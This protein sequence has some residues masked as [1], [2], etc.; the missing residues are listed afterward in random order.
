MTTRI[1]LELSIDDSGY[2]PRT[3]IKADHQLYE[4]WDDEQPTEDD[5]KYSASSLTSM[6]TKLY[7]ITQSND[8]PGDAEYYIEDKLFA[9]MVDGCHLEL[10]E[11]ILDDP[12]LDK[13]RQTEEIEM[14]FTNE[15]EIVYGDNQQLE[16]GQIA[17]YRN[18][19]IRA[20]DG[21]DSRSNNIVNKEGKNV[22]NSKEEA[23]AAIKDYYADSDANVS[24][25]DK[26]IFKINDNENRYDLVMSNGKEIK[27]EEENPSQ[28]KK[29]TRARKPGI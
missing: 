27:P 28:K 26:T 29:R 8:L 20:Y 10:N 25:M 1:N 12:M 17:V 3:S 24:P 21:F 4:S 22:F 18:D 19:G 2:R 9:K 16:E 11:N 23:V 5:F 14:I 13:F 6:Y 7:D 15:I